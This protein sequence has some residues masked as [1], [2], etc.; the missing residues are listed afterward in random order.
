MFGIICPEKITTCQRTTWSSSRWI[1]NDEESGLQEACCY[2]TYHQ[3]FSLEH[4]SDLFAFEMALLLTRVPGRVLLLATWTGS[5]ISIPVFLYSRPGVDR[6]NMLHNG[7]S[8]V[9]F[10]QLN[11]LTMTSIISRLSCQWSPSLWEDLFFSRH[12]F[13]SLVKL[14]W[15]FSK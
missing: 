10:H 12:E 9:W 11:Q 6:A 3:K 2:L 4:E 1:Y 5:M 14:Q 7:T 15:L 8:G 13:E